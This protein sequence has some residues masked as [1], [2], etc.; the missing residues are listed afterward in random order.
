MA[1]AIR[2][3]L[4][5]SAARH[6][7][8]PIGPMLNH[9]PSGR[10]VPAVVWSCCAVSGDAFVRPCGGRQPGK[11]WGVSETAT[12]SLGR[13]VRSRPAPAGPDGAVQG[14]VIPGANGGPLAFPGGEPPRGV[15]FRLRR[16]ARRECR[17][18]GPRAGASHVSAVDSP[19]GGTMDFGLGIDRSRGAGASFPC[20]LPG[21][22]IGASEP[23][24][25]TRRR[26]LADG[27]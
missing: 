26:R 19:S 10:D 16:S 11:P 15:G 2:R 6:C 20:A 22:G 3:V 23:G 17:C 25:V 12:A 8:E 18:T 21:G 27:P 13:G 9:P 5:R 24:R 14:R 1:R 4:L 7:G